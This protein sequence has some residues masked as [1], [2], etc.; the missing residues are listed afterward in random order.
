MLTDFHLHTLVSDGELEP[1]ALL[2]Q[3]AAR[4]VTH[5]AITD[6]DTLG[7]YR[8][9]GAAVFE[10]ARRLG[11]ALTVGIEMDADW[12]GVEVHVL[13]FELRLDDP[14][15]ATHLDAVRAARFERARREI[16]IVNGLLGPGTIAEAEVFAP[17]RET[18]M[19][20]HFIHPL[21]DKGRFATYEE[22]NAWYRKNVKAG[23]AV[24]KPALAEAI[25]L[26]QGAGGWSALAH[27]AY[28]ERD[29][30]RVAPRLAELRAFGLDGVEVDYPYAACSP[31][32]FTPD[33]ATAYVGELREACTRLGLRTTRG[34]DSH[35]EADFERTYGAG[36]PWARG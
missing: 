33:R 22:A 28:Y 3:A 14:R 4:G 35:T 8:W 24:P 23:I 9:G 26:V 17:G 32:E 31:R 11:L 16:G 6:H 34:S 5:L 36:G 30:R 10:E 18:L 7:A 20:P 19:K 1:A 21:L 29:G 13:G 12:E 27:P 15:L 25:R 2:R